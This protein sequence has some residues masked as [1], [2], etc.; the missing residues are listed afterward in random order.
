MQEEIPV[1]AQVLVPADEYMGGRSMQK[2]SGLIM[3]YADTGKNLFNYFCPGRLVILE[4]L[5]KSLA[6]PFV[7]QISPV[8]LQSATLLI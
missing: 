4:K 6:Y 2:S 3:K 1:D 5:E 8:C 7:F